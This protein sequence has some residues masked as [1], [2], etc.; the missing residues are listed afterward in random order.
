MKSNDRARRLLAPLF[1][2]AGPIAIALAGTGCVVE[3]GPDSGDG[4]C[5]PN[6]ILDYEIQNAAGG[7]VTC[8]GAGAQTVQATVDGVMFPVPCPANSAAGS[9]TVPLQGLGTYNATID[10]YDSKGN[11]LAP[12]QSTSFSI[13]SCGDTETQTP[14]I[15]V[16]SPPAAG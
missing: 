12:A 6:L 9:V 7:P 8:A 2:L 16:V 3:T 13:S 1:F 14:A 10:V 5:Y 4:S 11:P 15:L